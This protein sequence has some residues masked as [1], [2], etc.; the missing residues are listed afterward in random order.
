M[1]RWYC[2]WREGGWNSRDVTLMSVVILPEIGQTDEKK[3]RFPLFVVKIAK[4][5]QIVLAVTND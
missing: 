1:F 4:T 5:T 3:D 2:L